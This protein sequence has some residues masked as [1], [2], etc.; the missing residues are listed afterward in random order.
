MKVTYETSTIFFDGLENGELFCVNEFSKDSEILMKIR[1]VSIFGDA[2]NCVSLSE[3][4]LLYWYDDFTAV[5][6]LE[7]HLTIAPAVT[8]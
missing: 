8:I 2:Y 4:G 6:P 7:G 3:D 1:E 5:T